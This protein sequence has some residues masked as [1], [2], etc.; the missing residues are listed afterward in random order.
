MGEQGV[1]NCRKVLKQVGKSRLIV[2]FTFLETDTAKPCTQ[3]CMSIGAK[4]NL[5]CKAIK[6]FTK[7]PLLQERFGLAPMNK[8]GVRQFS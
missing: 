6:P 8:V 4:P 7:P 2:V 5:Y 1:K 3:S